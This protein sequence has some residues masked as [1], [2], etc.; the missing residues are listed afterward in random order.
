MDIPDAIR[1]TFLILQLTTLSVE[2]LSC[3]AVRTVGPDLD[4]GRSY[5]VIFEKKSVDDNKIM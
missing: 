2:F 4:P 5:R 1:I 3:A